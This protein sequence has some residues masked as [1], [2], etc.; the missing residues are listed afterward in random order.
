MT[1]R[2]VKNIFCIIL[3][4]IIVTAMIPSMGLSYAEEKA[5]N[6]V[7]THQEEQ[8]LEN[9]GDSAQFGNAAFDFQ[10]DNQVK[11]AVSEDMPSKLDL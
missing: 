2:T 3:S 1:N 5:D 9:L 6:D 8:F 11:N 10:N 4:S 7:L